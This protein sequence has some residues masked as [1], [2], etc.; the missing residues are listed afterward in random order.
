M[1]KEKFRYIADNVKKWEGGYVYCSDGSDDICT[2]KGVTL[3]VYQMYFGKDKTCN[4]LRVMKESEWDYIFTEKF[5]NKLKADSIRNWSIARLCV[6][7]VWM[8]G[9]T[10]AIKKI[11]KACGC[12]AD[13]IVGPKTLKA[14]NNANSQAVFNR[15]WK[16]RE[17][18][19]KDI[20]WKNPA[21]KKYLK[22]WMNRLNDVKY[23]PDKK[24]D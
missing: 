14:L 17:Q 8:S 11:Q 19:Y 2:M 12:T 13:G 6:D 22:G 21:K 5:Y 10:T 1:N 18:W 20:V 16:M 4:D 15:L 23:I 3:P 24:E 9:L 7:M